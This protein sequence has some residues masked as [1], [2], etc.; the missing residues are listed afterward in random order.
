M[1]LHRRFIARELARMAFGLLRCAACF[2][3]ILCHIFS[4]IYLVRVPFRDSAWLAI[5]W[6]GVVYFLIDR[7]CRM[8]EPRRPP[9]A[10]DFASSGFFLSVAGLVLIIFLLS[11][12]TGRMAAACAAVLFAVSP[13]MVFFN[14]Y[15]I[16]ETLLVFFTL[17]A[18]AAGWRYARTGRFAWCRLA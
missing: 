6:A 9:P 13:A 15:Y 8:R 18:I 3:F 14:R 5:C 12:A 1:R 11:W 2:G 17:A 16:H 10:P 7:L 4:L